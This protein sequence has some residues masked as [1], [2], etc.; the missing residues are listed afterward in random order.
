MARYEMDFV[1]TRAVFGEPRG[2]DPNYRGG[3]GGMRMRGGWGR[4][5]YGAH[6]FARAADLETAGG[7]G[8]MY[9][10]GSRPPRPRAEWEERGRVRDSFRDRA[11]IEDFNAHSPGLARGGRPQAAG[12]G[13]E[14]ERGT[15]YRPE[16]S[17]RGTGPAGFGEGWGRGPMRGGR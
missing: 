13:H 7:Y 8:G 17:N 5:P 10:G 14:L 16:Y 15:R 2:L 6:R 11:M 4:A 9:G 3:Y 1:G 12:Y